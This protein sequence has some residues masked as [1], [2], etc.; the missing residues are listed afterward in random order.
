VSSAAQEPDDESFVVDVH[1]VTLP[2]AMLSSSA[3]KPCEKSL[4]SGMSSP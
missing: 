3:A 4:W 1:A 2:Q